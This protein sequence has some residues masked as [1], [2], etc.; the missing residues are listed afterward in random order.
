MVIKH[1]IMYIDDGDGHNVGEY[2]AIQ[3]DEDDW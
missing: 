1:L 2:V 3:K